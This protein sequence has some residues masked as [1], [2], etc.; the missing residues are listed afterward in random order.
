MIS[1]RIPATC[2]ARFTQYPALMESRLVWESHFP[3]TR[4]IAWHRI[5]SY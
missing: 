2:I 4:R 3:S 5:N 1:G